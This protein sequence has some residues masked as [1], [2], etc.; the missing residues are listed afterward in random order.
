MIGVKG[1]LMDYL[2]NKPVEEA[3]VEL[4]TRKIES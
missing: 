4:F 3:L 2:Q 1:Q